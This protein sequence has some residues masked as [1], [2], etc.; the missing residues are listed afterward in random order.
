[1]WEGCVGVGG[2]EGGG[3]H[4]LHKTKL[5]FLLM[6]LVF[7]ARG[8]IHISLFF[9]YFLIQALFNYCSKSEG[10]TDVRQPSWAQHK[11]SHW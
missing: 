11:K 8:K 9:L 6:Q 3:T 4:L 2:G 5:Y 1:M 7:F 10:L